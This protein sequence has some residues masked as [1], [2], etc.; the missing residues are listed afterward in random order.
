MKKVLKF[1]I[2]KKDEEKAK[3]L[4]KSEIIKYNKKTVNFWNIFY[5]KNFWKSTNNLKMYQICQIVPKIQK[6]KK[7]VN[8]PKM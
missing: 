4:Q 2:C 8:G 3:K 5:K 1:K 7:I 6:V